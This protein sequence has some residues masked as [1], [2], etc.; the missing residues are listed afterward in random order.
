MI[1]LLIAVQVSQVQPVLKPVQ[2]TTSPKI[3]MAPAATRRHQMVSDG[4]ALLAQA[5]A[6]RTRGMHILGIADLDPQR[7]REALARVGWP[8]EQAAARG[9]GEAA[10]R[11]TTWIGEDA[12]ALI[13]HPALDV[14]IDATGHPAAG[15]AHALAATQHGNRVNSGSRLKR[16]GP[17]DHVADCGA[18]F[19]SAA[20]P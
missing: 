7:A 9:L 15:I 8:A 12:M 1:M 5:Q 18:G 6:R 14:A 11:G 10:E 2:T 16:G 19:S 20:G 13:G 17:N 4:Q 3:M